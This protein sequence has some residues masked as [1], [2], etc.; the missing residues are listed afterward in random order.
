[1]LK[2]TIRRLGALAMVLAMAVSVFAVNAS[3]ADTTDSGDNQQQ[4][5]QIDALKLTKRVNKGTHTYAPTATFSF[6]VT[7]AGAS[8][9][10][11]NPYD[12]KTNP[13][14]TVSSVSF[15]PAERDIDNEY[16]E[17]DATI[18]VDDT[19]LEPGIYYFTISEVVYA[20][21]DDNYVDG[22]SYTG[23]SKKL[24]VYVYG[25][26][27]DTKYMFVDEKG[28]NKVDGTFVNS[29]VNTADLTIGKTVTGEFGN[30]DKEFEFTLKINGD[31]QANKTYDKVN[32][33]GAKT[34]TVT[35][36]ANGKFK[37]KHGEKIV[38]PNLQA[39][40][41][42]E[43]KEDNYSGYTT[44]VA[45][46][47]SSD[48]KHTTQLTS[49]DKSVEFTNKADANPATGVIMTIAPYALMVVL[50]GAFAVVF[51]T[52]RNRAE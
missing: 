29:Y 31:P 37:L 6:T 45:G 48:M 22:V 11:T 34:G 2:K 51:L 30:K 4:E 7:A 1:M 50:A 20:A 24:A 44:T 49:V 32:S 14:V 27:T 23:G 21:G 19:N 10:V 26:G 43:V 52:R 47:E 33:N 8:A 42:Y 13:F 41:T 39:K 25:D 35:T 17:K 18:T 36:D 28:E 15:T 38:V 9:G 5:E 16:V 40:D 46:S 3:A 12:A